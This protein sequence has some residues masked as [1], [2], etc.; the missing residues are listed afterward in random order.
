M[1]R[2]ATTAL[3]DARRC[4]TSSWH[5]SGAV[6]P[7]QRNSL[8]LPGNSESTLNYYNFCLPGLIVTALLRL[9]GEDDELDR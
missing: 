1:I 4:L 5:D 8:L 3:R 2:H 6:P 9:E 7:R